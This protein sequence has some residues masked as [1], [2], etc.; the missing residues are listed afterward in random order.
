MLIGPCSPRTVM[1]QLNPSLF[2]FS[3]IH[4]T[5]ALDLANKSNKMLTLEEVR[6]LGEVDPEFQPVSTS[7]PLA[8][9]CNQL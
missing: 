8:S 9:G 4:N 5:N 6:A 2:I 3:Y 7:A 1:A